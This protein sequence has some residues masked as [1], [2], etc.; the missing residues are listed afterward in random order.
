MN[1]PLDRALMIQRLIAVAHADERIIGLI[2]YGSSS[3]GRSDR[4]SDVDVA[5]FTRERDFAAFE[6]DW[7]TWVSQFGPLLLAYISGVGHPWTVYDAV[8]LPLRVDFA[9]HPESA[10][11]QIL[12]W[13]NA[14]VSVEAMV[15]YDATGGQLTDIVRQLIGQSL[16]P[17]DL[18]AAFERIA[19]DFWYYSLRVLGKIR[20][21]EEWAARY[22]F[23]V[24]VTGLLH[25]LLRLEV[26]AVARWR[27]SE[28]AVGI[29]HV[30]SPQRLEQLNACIPGKGIPNLLDALRL[31]IGLAD[32]VCARIHVMHGWPWPEHVAARMPALL[33]MS[34]ITEQPEE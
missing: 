20:R 16:A 3:E 33:A 17:E 8:P 30:L 32:T 2:D 4:Y 6:R 31:A 25:A 26:G 34:P 5:V 23:T 9:L 27:A 10:A 24:I 7:K 28:S 15:W 1:H 22:E 29:E 14:P 12:T 21:G 11:T 18:A 19:G 13:P